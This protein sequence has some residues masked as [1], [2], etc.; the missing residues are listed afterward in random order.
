[1]GMITICLMFISLT[2]VPLASLHSLLAPL[3][4][5][6]LE[7]L[8]DRKNKSLSL[9]YI[10]NSPTHFDICL[11]LHTSI[12]TL[13]WRELNTLGHL[14]TPRAGHSTVAF[15]KK[16]FVFGGFTDAQNLYNDLYMLDIG[17]YQ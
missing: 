1:M 15:G 14:L 6:Y 16:L 17:M 8:F 10:V 9:Q 2:Q 3:E 5:Y 13:V 7:L 12:D 11:V 4:V